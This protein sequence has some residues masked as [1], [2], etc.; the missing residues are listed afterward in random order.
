MVVSGR[1]SK[2]WKRKKVSISHPFVN[3][4]NRNSWT[5][6]PFFR[7]SRDRS[8]HKLSL[9]RLGCICTSCSTLNFRGWKKV[10]AKAEI[11]HDNKSSNGFEILSKKTTKVKCKLTLKTGR[12]KLKLGGSCFRDQAD[13]NLRLKCLIQFEERRRLRLTTFL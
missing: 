11:S 12:R 10:F 5:F 3:K 2:A 1:K 8:L 13:R 6:S 9:R 4:S 7:Y